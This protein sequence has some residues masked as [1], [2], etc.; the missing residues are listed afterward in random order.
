[1]R[2]VVFDLIRKRQGGCGSCAVPL[3]S[4]GASLKPRPPCFRSIRKIR[5]DTQIES[6]RRRPLREVRDIDIFVETVADEPR[7]SQFNRVLSV[8]PSR[9][10]VPA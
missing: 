4:H 10:Q 5:R 8:V 3:P 1:M 2:I 7:E 6:Q 9:P